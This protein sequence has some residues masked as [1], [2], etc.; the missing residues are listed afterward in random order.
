VRAVGVEQVAGIHHQ[1]AEAAERLDWRIATHHYLAAGDDPDARRVL[2]ASIGIILATGAYAA[3]AELASLIPGGV[4]DAVG[5][6]LRSRVAQQHADVRAALEYAEE[7]HSADPESRPGLLNL[8]TARSLA[9]D[10]DGAMAAG[11]VLES[12]RD[13]LLARIARCYRATLATSVEG[14][15]VTAIAEARNLAQTL[16]GSGDLHY[17]GV[18]RL[19]LAYLEKA[20]GDVTGARTSAESAVGLLAET[21]AGV[22]LTSARLAL[23]WTL[24]SLGDLDSARR[25]IATAAA[26]SPRGQAIE[27]AYETAEIEGLFG[28]SIRAWQGLHEATLEVAPDSDS[29]A[30]VLLARAQ[31]RLRDG[32]VERAALD[33]QALE[34]NRIRTAPTFELRRRLAAAEVAF[35]RRDPAA[36]DLARG[37]QSLAVSQGAA[38]SQARSELIVAATS[39][40]DLSRVVRRI[41]LQDSSVLSVGAEVALSR[42]ED[43]EEDAAVLLIAEAT[44]R[45][46]RWIDSVRR[47]LS[48]GSDDHR[49]ALAL[50]LEQIGQPE[51]VARLSEV[52]KT[53]K[54]RRLRGLGKSLARR[55]APR[56]VIEDLG[57]LR[58]KVG[59]RLVE[60]SE[61]RR[62]VLGLL[63]LL[64]TM[65]KMAATREEVLEHLWPDLDPSSALN[66]LNQT[67][68]FL[69][70]VFEPDYHDDTSPTYVHQ[71]GET[72]WLDPEL[73]VSR[74]G[75][76][77]AMIRSLLGVPTP[78]EAATLA[79]EYRARF[80]LDFAYED[81]ASSYRDQLHASYLR[82]MEQAIRLDMDSGH[83]ARAT[84]LAERAADVEPDS[85][86]LQVVL[87]HLYRLSGAH[88]AATE[89]YGRYAENLRG[90]GVE[91]PALAD[92]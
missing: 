62:R 38:L 75:R 90:I 52:A 72:I 60:G 86:D 27:V 25:E 4:S 2:S 16:E 51:D 57:R 30:Q 76:C 37:A 40:A 23:A 34:P 33:I 77:R 65:P 92:V 54:D 13:D 5:L 11:G 49:V 15:L 63:C 58:V 85:D 31:L 6:I 44:R 3:A 53:V 18:A 45:P 19:N 67:V 20:S 9:G 79:N 28:N 7:A 78:D 66:S 89:Q 81:W 24:A 71:D 61:I 87:I 42:I 46:D 70:R 14:S 8:V 29:G 17:L 35:F 83:I 1:V 74:S 73:V 21:S 69:R 56:V 32:E 91:P 26:N 55:L 47:D 64:V 22:E 41:A 36:L 39:A 48:S 43:L 10:M 84:F 12:G 88:A 80:A 50:L 82:V 68:Y 59:P